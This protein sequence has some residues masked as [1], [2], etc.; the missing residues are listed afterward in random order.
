MRPATQ[1]V[2]RP[3]DAKLLVVDPDGGVRHAPT[4]DMTDHL[5]PG[6]LLVANDAATIPASLGGHHARTGAVIEVRL[7]GRRSLAIDD[8]YDFTAIVFG[9]GDHRTRTEHR[10]PPPPFQIGDRL[11]LGPLHATVVRLLDHP[12]L[13][14]LSFVG[15]PADIW[16]GIAR[17]G[18]PIQYA[19]IEA[20][21]AIWD[22]WTPMAGLL[23]AFEPPS[24]TFALDW[25]LLKE[26]DAR[27]IG[28]RTLTH[29]AG[30]SSTGDEDLDGRLP[31]D[32]AYYI[33]QATV[34]AI[35]ETRARGGRV[36]ALGSTV[37]RALE[38]AASRSHGLRAGPGLATQRIGA[39]T[40]L[41][42]VDA[43]VSGAHEPS[44]SH[45]E[46][47][48]AFADDVVLRCMS[49]M[50]DRDEYRSHEFGDSV[51]VSAR[52]HLTASSV[53]HKTGWP[54]SSIIRLPAVRSYRGIR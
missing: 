39:Q 53:A 28:F 19:H 37:T 52:G 4:A 45:Y 12:R 3:S 33:P 30:V 17:H 16:R 36:V 1:A 26:L 22:T 20:P 32:E 48:R 43:I 7:A 21:M 50:L 35:A 38:H 11:V 27:G 13:V 46:L 47:L 40:T 9:A 15:A 41:R 42:V 24:A 6:D 54:G 23:A 49:A 51:L 25:A 5:N 44:E 18:R 14:A 8:V 2:Q 29:A 10:P 31:L 34:A